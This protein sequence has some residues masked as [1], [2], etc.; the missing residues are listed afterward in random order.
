MLEVSPDLVRLAALTL[1]GR[2]PDV[3]LQF[4]IVFL[5]RVVETPHVCTLDEPV[6]VVPFLQK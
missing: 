6:L 5:R 2:H 1:L 4:L 3:I